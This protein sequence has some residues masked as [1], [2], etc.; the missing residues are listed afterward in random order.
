ML[1]VMTCCVYFTSS[2]TSHEPLDQWCSSTTRL[3]QDVEVLESTTSS[4]GLGGRGT[5]SAARTRVIWDKYFGMNVLHPFTHSKRG[6]IPL[7]LMRRP[8]DPLRDTI[9][10]H[11]GLIGFRRGGIVGRHWLSVDVHAPWA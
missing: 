5:S 7:F 8:D 11:E 6:I 3:C 1:T 2:F 10:A 4:S 9:A